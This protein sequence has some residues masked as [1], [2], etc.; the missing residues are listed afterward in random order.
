VSLFQVRQLARWWEVD[1]TVLL[2]V[3]G[4]MSQTTSWC[5]ASSDAKILV[6]ILVCFEQHLE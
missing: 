5:K 2:L 6:I 1:V 4:V 3:G